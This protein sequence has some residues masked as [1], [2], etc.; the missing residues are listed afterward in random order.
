MRFTLR[1]KLLAIVGVA[2]I[3]LIA[4]TVSNSVSEHAVEAQID[5]IRDTYL[6]KIR[7][8]PELGA[9]FEHLVRTIQNAVEA[10]DMDLLAVAAADRDAVLRSVREAGDALTAGQSATLRL[11]M[12]DYYDS[13]VAVSRRLIAGDGGEAAAA[14]MQDMQAKRDRVA[15]LIDQITSFDEHALTAAFAATKVEQRTALIVRIVV[16]AICLLALLAISIWIGNR[17][18][19]NLGAVIAEL[20]RFG[21]N[22][23]N[24]AI[25]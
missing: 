17:L 4:L 1:L 20:E 5:S 2:T 22:D 25:M 21:H 12:D 11:A 8:R 10:A 6:P 9:A 19:A 24:T 3:A 23:F 7:L 16:S 15:G 18:F 14:Q 13:A